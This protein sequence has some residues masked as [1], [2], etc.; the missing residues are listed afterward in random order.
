MAGETLSW[1]DKLAAARLM[2]IMKWPWM[3]VALFSLIPKPAQGLG[4]LGVTYDGIMHVDP[5]AIERWTVPEIAAA[6]IHEVTHVLREHNI[7]GAAI[8]AY[9]EPWN[10]SC[11]PGDVLLE[12]GEQIKTARNT[13]RE[14]SGELIEIFTQVGS[15]AAT[16][17]H[18]LRAR[19][20]KHKV[21]INPVILRDAV[22][23]E[24]AELRVGDYVLVPCLRKIDANSIDLQPFIQKGHDSKGRA[25]FG[26]RAIKT[27]DITPD[28]AWLIGLWVA[29]GSASPPVQFSL[30]AH[31]LQIIERVKSIASTLGYHSSQ[32]VR[33]NSVSVTLGS[34]VFG[35]W[36]KFNCG[37]GAH[38]KRV[39]NF[40]LHHPDKDIRSA[41]LSGLLMGDGCVRIQGK[42]RWGIISTVSSALANGVILLLA[43]DGIGAHR[44]IMTKGPRQIGASFTHKNLKLYRIAYNLDGV[45]YSTR[46]MKGHEVKA[47]HGRW[48]SNDEGVWYPIKRVVKKEFKGAVYNLVNTPDHVYVANSLLVHNC[49]AEINDD[50][51]SAEWTLPGQPCVP[52]HFGLPRG[53][54]AEEYYASIRII[55]FPSSQKGGSG[56]GD[57][58]E[59]DGIGGGGSAESEENPENGNGQES[60]D[61]DSAETSDETGGGSSPSDGSGSSAG[62]G[63]C[64]K[65]AVG[66]GWCGSCGGR[67]LPGEEESRKEV[68]GGRS[69]SE[70]SGIRRQ[71]AEA[72]RD[73]EEKSR[74]TVPA[75]WARWS[76]EQLLP[77][78]IDWRTK[79]ARLCRNFVA[80]RAGAVDMS[81]HKPSR[82]Q[83][84]LGYGNGHAVLP[85]YFAPVPRV[86]IM[87]DTSGSMSK[88]D[89]LRAVSESEGVMKAIGSEIAFFSL[90]A[91][92]HTVSKVRTARELANK[93]VGGGGTDFAPGFEEL[94][95]L[96]IHERP[97]IVVFMTD[98]YGPAP[99]N[100]PV[101]VDTIWVLIGEKCRKPWPHGNANVA[102]SWG[103]FVEVDNDCKE[104][105]ASLIG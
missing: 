92:V 72:I 93:L 20:R 66:Q 30:G 64:D 25:T 73:I 91:K 105:Q 51:Q 104:T 22:W 76:N 77:P 52:E 10:L 8:G 57:S 99:L 86:A 82:R 56:E 24:I 60:G 69:K 50:L 46:I 53:L 26:N 63:S 33:D 5:A 27:L 65:P 1:Q 80:R 28:L 61:R 40:I 21:G 48:K 103:S 88:G 90:D 37:S 97:K 71:T 59:S 14:F 89:L 98:G 11:F 83:A 2:A 54:T 13:A 58:S 101:G 18:P 6:V 29:E 7:R 75:N 15:L 32:S 12:N 78:K 41:F 36:L 42:K 67:A 3:R 45:S 79:L 85:A 19:I 70:M 87:V 34:V 17:E 38:N 100:P 81:Y 74:G 16:P 23:R 62:T 39:P 96:P 4:T 94:G 68:G 55:K 84:G 95:K 43:Q 49:D 35:R 9:P 47:R 31:E 102:L 44:S